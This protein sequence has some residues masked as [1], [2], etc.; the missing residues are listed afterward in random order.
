ML[1]H[2]ELF[3][4]LEGK[5]TAL[6]LSA[7]RKKLDG[8]TANYECIST[9][10]AL[11]IQTQLYK[12]IKTIVSNRRAKFAREGG[13]PGQFD[14][15]LERKNAIDFLRTTKKRGANHKSYNQLQLVLNNTKAPNIKQHHN[16]NITEKPTM[17]NDQQLVEEVNERMS[18]ISELTK[19]KE[20][21][22]FQESIVTIESEDPMILDLQV[23]AK[24]KR[25]VKRKALD[26]PIVANTIGVSQR[27]V[28]FARKLA[29]IEIQCLRLK[30]SGMRPEY[31]VH[32]QLLRG[33]EI[34]KFREKHLNDYD[35]FANKL[36]FKKKKSKRLINIAKQR[37]V[38]SEEEE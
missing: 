35:Q 27:D 7:I 20:Q 31:W 37:V 18:M 5:R 11:Q 15:D 34:L 33:P 26:S 12:E 19:N 30:L 36:K 1:R 16:K 3:N 22:F 9:N 4:Q 6:G 38:E 2:T 13:Q 14:E 32:D 8:L 23:A 25:A 21:G 10:T 17:R 28:Q 24:E 29:K